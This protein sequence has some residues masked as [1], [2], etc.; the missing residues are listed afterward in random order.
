MSY[1]RPDGGGCSLKWP[2][3]SRGWGNM[4]K[5]MS[6]DIATVLL[7]NETIR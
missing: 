4:E 7:A 5:G 3:K 1:I 2:H 6:F